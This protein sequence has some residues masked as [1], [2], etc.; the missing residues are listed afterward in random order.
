MS[1]SADKATG[2]LG[3]LMVVPMIVV[4]CFATAAY[5]ALLLLVWRSKTAWA[6][7]RGVKNV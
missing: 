3:W 1:K 7:A 5:G 2:L 6:M 4:A